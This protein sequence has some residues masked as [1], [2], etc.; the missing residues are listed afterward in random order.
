MG[1]VKEQIGGEKQ[2]T[3]EDE[4]KEENKLTEK[5]SNVLDKILNSEF[6]DSDGEDAIDRPVYSYS[7]SEGK[8]DNAILGSLQKKG[9]V[10][11]SEV[12]LGK[13]N[14]GKKDVIEEM[15]AITKR[16]YD[17]LKESREKQQK[18]EKLFDKIKTYSKGQ[19]IEHPLGFKKGDKV[20]FKNKGQE[21][22]GTFIVARKDA[23][24]DYV[25][26][27][28]NGKV[29]VRMPD[30]IKAVEKNL[31][32]EVKQEAVK[33]R[34]D[35]S[36]PGIFDKVADLM[37]EKRKKKELEN[38][39]LIKEHFGKDIETQKKINKERES[40]YYTIIEEVS[41][42]SKK[43][44]AHTKR[45]VI[46][47]DV[48]DIEKFMKE[49]YPKAEKISDKEYRTSGWI[50]PG[51]VIIKQQGKQFKMDVVEEAKVDKEIEKQ[52]KINKEKEKRD[53]EVERRMK[54]GER[55]Q[56]KMRRAGF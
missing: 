31:T 55:E 4:K 34:L 12:N 1:N 43:K 26:V 5:E 53:K 42:H 39:K 35:E 11:L 10:K 17:T 48:K 13:V 54:R 36:N 18:G 47:K 9:L 16:G 15:V 25:K 27:E 52:K 29:F 41:A 7:V 21:V 51:K 49:K 28:Y 44:G 8:S 23:V 37:K 6:Q 2:L 22:E 50:F 33:K 30:K 14:L 19:I 45:F 32:K 38:E 3:K 24:G 46:Q 56:R 20:L 40:K